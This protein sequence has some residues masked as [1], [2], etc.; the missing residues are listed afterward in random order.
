MLSNDF[1]NDFRTL[2]EE[3]RKTKAFHDWEGNL[4]D[5]LSIVKENPEVANKS[6][7]RI[8]N[9]IMKYGTKE[10]HVSEKLPGYEDLVKYNYFEG[11]IFGE[12]SAMTIHDLMK[13]LKASAKRTATRKKILILVGPVA[14][15]KS[16]TAALIKRALELDDL[17]A[18]KIKGCPIH[19]DPLNAIPLEDREKWNDLLGVHIEGNLCPHCRKEIKDKYTD[20]EGRI[21][22]E[23]IPVESFRPSE[24]DRIGIGTFQP[25]DPKSQDITELIGSVN[26]A[27]MNRYG[28]GDPRGYDFNGEL[29]IANRGMI[30]Y[31]EILKADIKF[32][33]TLI[34]LAEE[35]VIKAPKFPQMYIDTTMISHTNQ[36]EYDSFRSEKKNEALHD[37][38]Y[39]ISAPYNLKVDEEIEIYKKMIKESDFKDIHI[40][41]GTLRVAA[42]FAVLSRLIKDDKLTNMV[43][44]M[45]IYNGETTEHFKKTEIDVKAMRARGREKGEGMFGISPRFVIQSLNMA[46]ST[47][48]DKKCITP[49]DVIRALK[50][51][52]NHQVGFK[53]EDI[54]TLSN[55]LVGEKDSVRS[56]Y[57]D[58][59]QKEVNMAF[60]YAYEDQANELFDRYMTNVT[61]FCRKEQVQD[62]VTGEWSPPDEE[63]MR[64]LEDYIGVPQNSKGE[65]R[66][67]VFVCKAGCLER[68]E[69]FT[70]ES[71]KPLKEA[72][73]L[74]L[75][76][77][78]KN[79][80]NLSIANPTNTKPKNKEQRDKAFRT[81][82]EKGYCDHCANVLLAF[83]G[84]ILR[85]KN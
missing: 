42:Q 38:M 43:E 14:A 44:K 58:F 75:M 47:K 27:K 34:S 52:F 37:R 19:E 36:T 20:E 73:E 5:Y 48:E 3:Q 68:K 82:K 29:Q 70:Y 30:E 72:I 56:E 62:M 15:G 78:L 60:L 45:K 11:K 53:D 51:N 7:A 16:T 8:Y 21:K 24:Q 39:R 74:K 65:F 12:S 71:Y 55:I 25:S 54:P 61:A 80:V 1:K 10:V 50:Q 13:F 57:V 49:I 23:D 59:A 35:Q 9:A 31:I 64:S 33:Y 79:V 76:N 17:P 2:I 69:D 85:K 67:G 81:L 84:Q 66:N 18:F 77:D 40:A 83:V 32:H 41:P 22:W 6:A 4:F 63:L 46:L 26:I 28:E